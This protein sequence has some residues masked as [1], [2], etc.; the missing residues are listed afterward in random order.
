MQLV[1][2]RISRPHGIRGELTVEVR[3]D[4]PERRFAAGAVLVTE[5]AAAGPL[6]VAG[7]GGTPAGCWSGLLTSRTG[8]LRSRCAASLLLVDSADLE[9]LPDPDELS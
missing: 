3:T 7:T 1:V 5:P 8:P 2:G 6:T 9:D 4:D